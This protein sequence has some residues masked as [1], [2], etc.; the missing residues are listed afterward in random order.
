MEN[1]VENQIVIKR[2][3]RSKLVRTLVLLGAVTIGAGAIVYGLT[4]P[5]NE[6]IFEKRARYLNIANE[7]MLQTQDPEI[8]NGLNKVITDINNGVYDYNK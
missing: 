3:P 5:T 2:K 7:Q 1:Y 6:T 4:D 8:I